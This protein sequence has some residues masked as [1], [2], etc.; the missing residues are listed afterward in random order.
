LSGSIQNIPTALAQRLIAVFELVSKRYHK[1]YARIQSEL[2]SSA[3]TA[4]ASDLSK[5]P[6]YADFAVF[7]DMLLSLLHAFCTIIRQQVNGK[8]EPFIYAL[9]QSRDLYPSLQ[10]HPRMTKYVDEISLV[11]AFFQAHLSIFHGST[12]EMS[13]VLK[14]IGTAASKWAN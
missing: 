1:L 11:I 10:K 7:Q 12:P 8:N 6:S 13:M 14:M 4:D 9:L 3:S 2:P 5:C